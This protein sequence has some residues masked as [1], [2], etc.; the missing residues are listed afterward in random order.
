ML[1][2]E[3]LGVPLCMCCWLAQTMWFS[4]SLPFRFSV[5]ALFLSSVCRTTEQQIQGFLPCVFHST[6]QLASMLNLAMNPEFISSPALRINATHKKP[7][8]AHSCRHPVITSL[9]LLG[10]RK[11]AHSVSLNAAQLIARRN[12]PVDCAWCSSTHPHCC[13]E[14]PTFSTSPPWWMDSG[15]SLL[16]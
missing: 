16:L 12:V 7:S 10:Q 6:P 9:A 15:I 11:P 13:L 1:P 14:S 2:C 8:Y 4:D 5:V 3:V